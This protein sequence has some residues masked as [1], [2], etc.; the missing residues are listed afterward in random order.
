MRKLAREIRGLEHELGVF[1]QGGKGAT[2]RKTPTGILHR[3]DRLSIEA[4]PFVY[5]SRMAATVDSAAVPHRRPLTDGFV[6]AVWRR[7]D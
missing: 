4:Q 5:A 2:S 7:R 3:C 1:A 6:R